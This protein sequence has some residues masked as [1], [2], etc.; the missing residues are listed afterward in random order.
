MT[1]LL[2]VNNKGQMVSWYFDAGFNLHGL[3][4]EPAKS[5]GTRLDCFTSKGIADNLR[6]APLW[7]RLAVSDQVRVKPKT[8]AINR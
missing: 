1:N 5:P 3:L 2:G 7:E 6:A 4:V 8:L